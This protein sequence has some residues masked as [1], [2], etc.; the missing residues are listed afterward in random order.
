[1]PSCDKLCICLITKDRSLVGRK[2]RGR[3]RDVSHNS[4]VSPNLTS[5]KFNDFAWFFAKISSTSLHDF[6]SSC[7]TEGLKQCNLWPSIDEIWTN[8]SVDDVGEE[9]FSS[10]DVGEF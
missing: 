8:F 5:S 6:C 10:D 4:S 1:M 9:L 7:T 3:E 2:G